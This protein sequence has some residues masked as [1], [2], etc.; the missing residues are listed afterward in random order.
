MPKHFL[1]FIAARHSPG[2]VVVPQH[3]AISAVANDLILMWAAT[4][5]EEWE[6]QITYLPL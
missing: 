5:A 4:E 1:A 3:L 6:N 2:L